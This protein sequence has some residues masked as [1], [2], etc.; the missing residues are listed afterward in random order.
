M[1]FGAGYGHYETSILDPLADVLP[2]PKLVSWEGA[3]DIEKLTKGRVAALDM[4]LYHQLGMVDSVF[5]FEVL[6]HIPAKFEAVAHSRFWSEKGGGQKQ[7]RIGT[8][9]YFSV[10]LGW[11]SQFGGKQ[12]G[13]H[14]EE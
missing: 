7:S 4:T 3:A 13:G 14:E 11:F 10:T 12:V 5:C 9:F 8:K 1:N 6:E 2:I